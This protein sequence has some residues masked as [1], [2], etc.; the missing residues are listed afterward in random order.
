MVGLTGMLVSVVFLGAFSKFLAVQENSILSNILSTVL[1]LFLCIISIFSGSL[2]LEFFVSLFSISSP[3]IFSASST[4]IAAWYLD[5]LPI[6]STV[7]LPFYSSVS[8][9]FATICGAETV[10]LPIGIALSV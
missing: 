4:S 9:T 7:S 1:K 2:S 10:R 6:S 8:V 5:L 3:I